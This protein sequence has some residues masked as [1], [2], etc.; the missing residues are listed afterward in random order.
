MKKIT[1][2]PG[3]VTEIPVGRVVPDENQPRKAFR[4]KPLD[5]LAANIKQRGI[6]QPITVV[7][8]G[9]DFMIK[10][11]ERRWRAGKLAGL[12]TVPCLLDG[13]GGEYSDLLIDQLSENDLREGLNPIERALTFE[14]LQSAGMGPKQISEHLASHGINYSRPAVSNTLRL[15]KL[16]DKARDQV[17]AGIL[18]ESYARLLVPYEKFPKVIDL[19]CKTVGDEDPRWVDKD[20]VEGEITAVLKELGIETTKSDGCGGD[21]ECYVKGRSYFGSEVGFCMDPKKLQV[22]R[23]DAEDKK[24]AKAAAKAPAKPETDPTKAKPKKL[25]PNK[26]GVVPL[27]R[28]AY[29]SYR[30]LE[31]VDFDTSDC[32]NCPHSASAS[33]NGSPGLARL[34]CFYTPCYEN[35]ERQHRKILNREGSIRELIDDQ[36]LPVLLEAATSEPVAKVILLPLL[37]YV[38]TDYPVDE[39]PPTDAHSWLHSASPERYGTGRSSSDQL[40]VAPGVIGRGTLTQLL[41][42]DLTKSDTATIVAAIVKSLDME[43]RRELA[44]DL[45]IDIASFWS[46]NEA[47]AKLFTKPQIVELIGDKFE[48]PDVP[49]GEWRQRLADDTGVPDLVREVWLSKIKN[50]Y[51]AEG[52]E[53]DDEA[54]AA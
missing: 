12:K 17:A 7:P 41:S 40:R 9:T 42:A 35:L 6:L 51:P 28:R 24:A 10:T 3:V 29:G 18:K 21:C 15:L 31:S 14:S 49:A 8:S 43:Q 46:N 5:D 47:Y 25:T 36:L 39:N 4:E 48:G 45:S 26:E 20:F 19:V 53:A 50:V 54:I 13:A 34:T 23:A 52:G 44:L 11:G 33:H 38:A 37:V 27:A 32:A 2:K 1:L 16:P 30:S 22:K